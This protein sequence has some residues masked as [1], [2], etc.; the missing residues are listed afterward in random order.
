METG[1]IAGLAG[2][3]AAALFAADAPLHHSIKLY[4]LITPE[5][6]SQG[7]FLKARIDGGPELRML[8]DSGAQHVILDKRAAARVGRS[9]GAAIAI[10]VVGLGGSAKTCR[11]TSPSAVQIGDLIVRDC[12]IMVVD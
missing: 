11:R 4:P 8:L 5:S 2:L 3:V 10:E 9:P 6:Q 12:E 7:L 1:R